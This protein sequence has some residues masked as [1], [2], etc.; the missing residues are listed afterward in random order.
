MLTQ[1]CRVEGEG[2][3]NKG[4]RGQQQSS[5]T[6]QQ[7]QPLA[8]EG[9]DASASRMQPPSS[10]P[11][12]TAGSRAPSNSAS[13]V[14]LP[15]SPPSHFSHQGGSAAVLAPVCRSAP[16]WVG[17]FGVVA[18]ALPHLTARQMWEVMGVA[19]DFARDWAELRYGGR[20]EGC[21]WRGA[22]WEHD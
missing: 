4:Q 1:V 16:G 8:M 6:E 15:S 22:G 18:P 14:P 21:P 5:Q 3:S 10:T 13:S 19:R 11:Q 9:L 7:Q 17:P 2:I 20:R 12:L